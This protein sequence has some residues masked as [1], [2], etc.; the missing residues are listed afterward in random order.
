MR[1]LTL[2]LLMT[3]VAAGQD[4]K[5]YLKALRE[6][7]S[8]GPPAVDVLVDASAQPGALWVGDRL[9]YRLQFRVTAGFELHLDDLDAGFL[10]GAGWE[11][12]DQRIERSQSD[13]GETLYR[14]EYDL[15]TWEPG[16]GLLEI[17]SLEVRYFRSGT[18]VGADLE[19]GRV[20]TGSL[21]VPLRSTLPEEGA[22]QSIR[23]MELPAPDPAGLLGR[24]FG[25]ALLLTGLGLAAVVLAG[26]FR[27]SES[28]EEAQPEVGAGDWKSL[29]GLPVEQV[30]DRRQA[31]SRLD[32]LLRAALAGRLVA[33]AQARTVDEL[34]AELE[35]GEDAFVDL[36]RRCE[37]GKYA[38]DALVPEAEQWRRDAAQA[39]RIGEAR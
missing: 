13:I 14:I 6:Q 19:S 11:I 38:P 28:A 4:G 17:P 39:K 23:P 29:D 10:E 26:R 25:V 21:R 33:P 1:W 30:E 20:A 3:G 5:A 37:E 9:V 18:P 24:W 7:A 15:T 2:L 32:R 27:S 36:L 31:Y 34:A 16:P 22:V 35:G 12:L 8:A